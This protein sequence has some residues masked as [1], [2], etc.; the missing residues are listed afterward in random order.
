MSDA[1]VAG[2]GG[3]P[4]SGQIKKELSEGII[5]QTAES[6]GSTCCT[7]L[8]SDVEVIKME[9][10]DHFEV[11]DPKSLQIANSPG[12]PDRQF[13]SSTTASIGEITT[14][15]D[16]KEDS[17][18]RLCLVCGDIASGFHY[19]VAS[20]EACKAF[21]KRTIQGNIEYNCPAVGDCEIN[22]RRRKACQACRFQK[23]LASGM[24]KEGVRLDRVRG[25]RQKY[26]RNPDTPHQLQVVYP[27]TKISLEDIK[28]LEVLSTCEP[29]LLHMG[30]IMTTT[31]CAMHILTAL[32]DLYDRE[33]VCVIGWAKQI[34]GFA[35]LP[36]NDQMRLLQGTWVELLT[37]TL[38]FRSLPALT[39]SATVIDSAAVATNGA[40]LTPS[41]R[42]A[43][44][45][46]LEERCAKE[47]NALE[48]YQQTAKVV[49][50]LH[51]TA[52]T[53]EEYYL[54]KAL[55]LANSDAKLEEPMALH[56]FRDVILN[57]L[58]DCVSVVSSSNAQSQLQ[59]LLLILP[60]LRQADYVVRKFWTAV[61][62]D[63][64]IS[65]N[66]LFVEMLEASSSGRLKYIC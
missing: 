10:S 54:L 24:L 9:I 43:T 18:R 66:K 57:A 60:T 7:A 4:N 17:P 65:M 58:S 55:A 36:L 16:I 13:C 44:D 52:C 39:T 25:G 11:V 6:P 3:Q 51:R 1:V 42:F 32:S 28:I 8:Y 46:I 53:K 22:K 26:R 62:H 5:Y 30:P 33:L 61:N 47:C 41:L 50:R 37:L 23:C 20:C 40:N 14:N 38:A 27:Q 19:G 63:G 49:E 64:K 59:N 31:D 35:D 21:F 34:P 29:E 48:L 2:S 56:K 45:F 12:S 15:D